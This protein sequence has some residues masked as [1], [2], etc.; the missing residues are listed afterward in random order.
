MKP[1][2]HLVY[3]TC[4]LTLAENEGM[5]AWALETF[6]C[7]ELRLATPYLG[8]RGWPGAKLTLDQLQMVQ[9]FGPEDNVDSI[10]FFIAHFRKKNV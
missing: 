7:L 2:G 8:G 6:N 3:S 10:G 1:G 5:V 4:T 9:R